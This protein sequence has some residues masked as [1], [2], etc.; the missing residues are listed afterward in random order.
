MKKRGRVLSD[1]STSQVMPKVAGKHRTKER[2]E[3]RIPRNFRERMALLHLD[4]RFLAS[5]N[6]ER[7]H[8]CCSNPLSLWFLV[9]SAL[10]N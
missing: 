5:G 6:C 10:G 9:M 1:V 2:Q 4:F 7:K 3:R 8:F